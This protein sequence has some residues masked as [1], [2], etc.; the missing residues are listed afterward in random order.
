MCSK[1]QDS[2]IS[3]CV[4]V[5]KPST[6]TLSALT[7]TINRCTSVLSF[8][9]GSHFCLLI[10]EGRSKVDSVIVIKTSGVT[11]TVYY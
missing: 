4:K 5:Y 7:I 3:V 6:S 1:I 8:F 10:L 11:V 2:E 9:L